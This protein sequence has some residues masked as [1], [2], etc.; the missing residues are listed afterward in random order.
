MHGD[1][2][3]GG[4]DACV[5]ED[6]QHTIKEGE[7]VKIKGTLHLEGHLTLDGVLQLDDP[8]DA[9]ILCASE[10]EN[11]ELYNYFSTDTA[12]MIF[13]LKELCERI[14]SKI[15][16]N[17]SCKKVEYT[18]NLNPAIGDHLTEANDLIFSK[19]EKFCIEHEWRVVWE[20]K[21]AEEPLIIE[22]GAINDICKIVYKKCHSR[23]QA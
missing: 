9:Y 5:F 14:S 17:Y 13:D 20:S 8:L 19:P 15:K 4:N 12:V 18:K 10:L 2:Q 23:V 11:E 6:E 21:D 16:L 1:T 7:T 22:I 3:E